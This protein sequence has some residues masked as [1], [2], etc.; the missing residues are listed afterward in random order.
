MVIKHY[1]GTNAPKPRFFI[2]FDYSEWSE[3]HRVFSLYMQD[4]NDWLLSPEKQDTPHKSGG[5]D[6]EHV[7]N[8]SMPPFCAADNANLATEKSQHKA[9]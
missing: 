7:S 5:A 4:Y 3:N 2:I 9:A 8:D 6:P 1:S